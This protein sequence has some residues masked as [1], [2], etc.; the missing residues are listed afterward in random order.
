MQEVRINDAVV[1]VDSTRIELLK[2]FVDLPDGVWRFR[3][4]VQMGSHDME[5]RGAGIA[6]LIHQCHG[7]SVNVAR[8]SKWKSHPRKAL[9]IDQIA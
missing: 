3:V 8:W 5:W 4:S 2:V 9:V 1:L 7:V 6:E